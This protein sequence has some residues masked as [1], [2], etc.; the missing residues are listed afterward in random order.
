MELLLYNTLTKSKEVFKPQNRSLIKLYVCGPTVYD[1]PHIGTARSAVIYDILFRTLIHVFG[2][3]NVLYVRNITD[4]DDKIIGRARDLNMEV[5]KL[6]KLTID[7][8]QQDMNYLNCLRPNIEPK[9]TEHV[10]E[11]I[12]II[13]KLIERGY[14]YI[15]DNHVYFDVAKADNYTNLSGRSLDQMI[16][17]VRIE[18]KESKKCQNDFVLWKPI[19][20][21]EKNCDNFSSPW[22]IGRPGWHIE[23]SAMSYKYLGSSFDIHGGGAD[24]I[25]PH[26]TNE[27]A[28]SVNAFPGST[29]ANLW[30][31]NG[32]LTV[33]GEKMSKSLGNFLTV[34]D[35]IARNISGDILRLLLMNTQYRKPLDFNDKALLD[36]R[37]T[38]DYWYGAVA[39]KAINRD[40]DN[41]P[42]DFLSALYDDL[43]T[44]LAVKIINDYAKL[45]YVS[46]NKEEQ[47]F[48]ANKLYQCTRFLGLMSRSAEKWFRN[49]T[50]V[51]E[52]EINQLVS[53]RLLAKKQGQ[54]QIAD[55]IRNK[56][57]SMNIILEDR[58]NNITTWRKK[59][60]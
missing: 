22:G 39:T 3:S 32:F 43:N 4:V 37:K 20:R 53:K 54:W 48:N 15:S 18:A 40:D 10:Q 26:H 57:L 2:I 17:S 14:A 9:A 21:G 33:N 41:L 55:E 16:N 11:M 30:V 45:A 49:D 28:Q 36:A 44:P 7:Y 27:I 47:N 1:R 60:N 29:F 58:P 56:L 35:M 42:G 23:C 24:L 51:D 6:T 46:V 8:F 25:F 52:E 13:T 34:E 59:N 38:L 50:D 19:G 12:S 31:H 5:S